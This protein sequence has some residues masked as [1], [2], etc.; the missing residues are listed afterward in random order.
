MKMENNTL[1]GTIVK[2]E[3]VRKA[4][5]YGSIYTI[6]V[7]TIKGTIDVKIIDTEINLYKMFGIRFK[8][9]ECNLPD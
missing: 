1:A 7:N 4:L 6:T 3:I 2:T 8:G 9:E 5:P